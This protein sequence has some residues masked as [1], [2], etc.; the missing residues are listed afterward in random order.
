MNEATRVFTFR[1]RP[2]DRETRASYIRRLL[3]ANGE[4][5]AHWKHLLRLAGTEEAG[6]TGDPELRLLQ[7]KTGR[8][9]FPFTREVLSPT[10][11]DGTS[12]PACTEGLGNQWMCILCAHGAT[13]EQGVQF[14]EYVCLKHALWVGAGTRPDQQ[15]NV[16]PDVLAAERTFRKLRAR[17][18]LEARLF[19][20]LRNALIQ[21][22]VI[23][24]TPETYPVLIR[25]A[26]LLTSTAFMRA[27]YDPTQPFGDAHKYLSQAITG[28]IG[29]PHRKLVRA[30]WLHS[31]STHLA[32]REATA[33]ERPFTPAWEH[34]LPLKPSV[35][36]RFEPVTDPLE[37]F[38]RFLEPTGDRKLSRS[39]T[40]EVLAHQLRRNKQSGQEPITGAGKVPT[41]CR[42]GHRL[43]QFPTDLL[44]HA[45]RNTDRCPYC[46]NR[47]A[48]PGFNSLE[49][50]CPEL[51]QQYEPALNNGRPVNTILA[52]S[53]DIIVWRCAANHLTEASPSERTA[54]GIGCGKCTGRI[55]SVGE[56]DLGTTHPEVAKTWHPRN[57]PATPQSV[58]AG[59]S[60]VVYWLCDAGHT[61]KRSIRSRT[62]GGGCQHCDKKE[63]RATLPTLAAARPDL[64]RE[65]DHEL[66]GTLTPEKVTTGSGKTVYWRCPEGHSYDQIIERRVAG[67]RCSICTHRRLDTGTNDLLTRE[68][69]LCA[70]WHPYLNYPAEPSKIVRGT[71]SFWWRCGHGHIVQQTVA[72]RL[73]SHGCTECDPAERILSSP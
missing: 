72:H 36:A 65:W 55:L 16:G 8:T 5:Q 71:G 60:D 46:K 6:A 42:E 50:T 3:E 9:E 32:V 12:C 35:A 47:E 26:A 49:V 14:T 4:T 61:Y 1:V 48:L 37:P 63:R 57:F 2:L 52:G 58:S 7:A 39:N 73:Q 69:V 23:P 54:G 51:A 13:V 64:A 45:P 66:N 17:N 56:N 20:I 41:V 11:S 27:F 68:P 30:I 43:Q 40:L 38:H 24:L 18:L 22:P 62:H 31:R 70:E 21:S 29:T 67:Y 25:L 34:D 59:M 10:H 15:I 44:R 19:L 28:V 33:G 53:H